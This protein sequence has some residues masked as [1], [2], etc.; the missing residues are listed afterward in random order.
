[1]ETSDLLVET[2][3]VESVSAV[4]H[5]QDGTVVTACPLLRQSEVG[6]PYR[7]AVGLRKQRRTGPRAA[8]QQRHSGEY[9]RCC[10]SHGRA[11]VIL[12]SLYGQMEFFGGKDPVGSDTMLGV[13]FLRRRST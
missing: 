9:D 7:R 8:A 12:P 2:L 3:V 1:M 10:S 13:R 4:E 5:G 11:L 6:E